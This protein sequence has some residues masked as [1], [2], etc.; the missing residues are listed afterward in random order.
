MFLTTEHEKGLKEQ[1]ADAQ[2]WTFEAAD[3]FYN[4]T[5]W[6]SGEKSSV[7]LTDRASFGL[8]M[9]DDRWGDA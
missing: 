1:S 2:Q 3:E 9:A 6:S 5:I 7:P 4:S 8:K